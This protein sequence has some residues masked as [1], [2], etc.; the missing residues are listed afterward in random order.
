MR[1]PFASALILTVASFALPFVTVS[2]DLPALPLPAFLTVPLICAPDSL[3]AL[4][5]RS[6]LEAAAAVEGSASAASIP[7][8]ARF[9]AQRHGL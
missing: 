5:L 1:L 9:T 8:S 4:T 7:R 3:S 6:G 2:F